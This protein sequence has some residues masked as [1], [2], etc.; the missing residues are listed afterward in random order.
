MSEIPVSCLLEF[1]AFIGIDWADQK[2]AWALQVKGSA[3]IEKGEMAST[4]ESIED[5]AQQ[6]QRRFPSSPWQ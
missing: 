4:P 1:A 3:T 2:H 5:W 6:L